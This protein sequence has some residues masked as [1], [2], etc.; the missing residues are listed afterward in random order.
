[1]E[2]LAVPRNP[3]AFACVLRLLRGEALPEGMSA[4]MRQALAADAAFF[5]VEGAPFEIPAT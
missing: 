5:Q 3:D 1:V 4:E 2:E